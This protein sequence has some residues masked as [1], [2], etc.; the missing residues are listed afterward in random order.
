MS[1]SF[2]VLPSGAGTRRALVAVVAFAGMAALAS[3]GFSHPSPVKRTYLLEAAAPATAATAK[4]ASV[5]VG[6][7]NVAA[8]FR[9]KTFVYR[10]SD[11]KYESD[12]YDEFFIPPATMLA[13]ATAR[14]LAAAKV[15]RRVVPASVTGEDG[16]YVLDGFVSELYGDARNAG[17][18][19]AVLGI[20]YYLSPANVVAP[21]VIWTRAYEKRVPVEGKGPEALARAWN[22]ALTS[23]L[24]DL[25]RDLAAAEL[26]GK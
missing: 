26:P 19:Q 8:P 6:V 15:F 4:P 11:L 1:L 25:A 17:A 5:R 24:A 12:F 2:P 14:A 16:D 23:I 22:S 13:D 21:S 7:V 20:S 9:A 3:C 18:P 10:E